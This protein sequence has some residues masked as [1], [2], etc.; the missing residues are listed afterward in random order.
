MPGPKAEQ[1]TTMDDITDTLTLGRAK[2]LLISQPDHVSFGSSAETHLLR[3]ANPTGTRIRPMEV[4]C[5]GR[6]RTGTLS[7]RVALLQL[8]YFDVYHMSVPLSEN[9]ADCTSWLRAIAAHNGEPGA[10][11]FTRQDWDALLGHCMAVTD[12]P[13]ALFAEELMAAYPDAKVVLSVRDSTAAWHKSVVDTICATIDIVSPYRN[14][15]PGWN[16]L[17]HL[18]RFFAPSMPGGKDTHKFFDA[19]VEA[20]DGD[21]IPTEGPTIYEA[22]NERVRRLV[23]ERRE[24][25]EN[26]EFLEFNVK[27]GWGPLCAFLGKEVPDT[28]FPRVND[29]AEF[30]VRKGVMQWAVPLGYALNVA[31]V[32]AVPAVAWGAFAYLKRTHRL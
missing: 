17:Y 32:L 29:S 7:L 6:E 4:L 19:A 1:I 23:R 14:R 10:A 30:M 12:Q 24:R 5:L 8:G 26:V 21:L 22:H 16:P 31:K 15:H 28:P 11:P 3:P 27:E 9:S 13:C 2:A 25:G 20:L 18:S